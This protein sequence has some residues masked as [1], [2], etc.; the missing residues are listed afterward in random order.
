MGDTFR[1]GHQMVPENTY[2]TKG[3]ACRLCHRV[4]VIVSHIDKRMARHRMQ[5]LTLYGR[6]SGLSPALCPH[7]YRDRE[8]LRRYEA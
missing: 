5:G 4:A 2:Q 3:P 7:R 1:C 6:G 8:W